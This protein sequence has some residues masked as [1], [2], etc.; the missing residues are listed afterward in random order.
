[1]NIP[2]AIISVMAIAAAIAAF[3]HARL[4]SFVFPALCASIAIIASIVAIIASGINAMFTKPFIS[5]IP[6]IY[7]ILSFPFSFRSS[8]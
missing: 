1:M 2:F 8:L 7:K 3:L 5:S 4:N 6:G